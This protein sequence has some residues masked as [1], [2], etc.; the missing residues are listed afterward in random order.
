MVRA[1]LTANAVVA[2]TVLGSIT[3]ILSDTVESE[4]RQM[5][6]SV[7]IASIKK[8][9]IKKNPPL[10]KTQVEKIKKTNLIK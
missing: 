4:G 7:W 1:L 6:S 2:A 10:K 9:K 5:K 3:S 8:G